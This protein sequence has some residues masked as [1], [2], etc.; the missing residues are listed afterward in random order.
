M[1]TPFRIVL[2]VAAAL[3]VLVAVNFLPMLSLKTPRMREYKSHGLT[4]YGN[5]TQSSVLI[6]SPANPGPAHSR[7]SIVQAAVHEYVH[8]ITDRRNHEL[9]HWLREGFALSL[10]GQAPQIGEIRSV[11][12][13]TFAEFSTRDSIRF[14]S[15][16]GYALAWTLIDYLTT[17]YGWE[18]VV[19]L[20]TPG[21]SYQS[22]LGRSA[23]DLFQDWKAYLAN[24]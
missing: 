8:V 6:T 3:V 14:A 4:V 12:D 9:S 23:E 20:T 1:K 7:Q 19:G 22:V 15:V 17:S 11:R 16:G 21:A 2:I 13:V 18:R 5:N 10:A 24:L